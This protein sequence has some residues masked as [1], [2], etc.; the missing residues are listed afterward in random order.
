[1]IECLP[2][3]RLSVSRRVVWISNARTIE[4]GTVPANHGLEPDDGQGIYNARNEAIQPNEHQ[5]V[6][7]A[8]NKPLRERAPQH[9]D[10]LP[11][12]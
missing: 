12:Q 11:A 9:I 5:S 1:M 8:E 2:P 3:A 7:S 6:E 10:L 4:S